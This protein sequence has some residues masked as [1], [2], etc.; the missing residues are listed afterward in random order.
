LNE[1]SLGNARELAR[2][3]SELTPGTSIRLRVLR[4]GQLR[5]VVITVAEFPEQRQ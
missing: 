3:V 2:R 5:D 1:S 4:M